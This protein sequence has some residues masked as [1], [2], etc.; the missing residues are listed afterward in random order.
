MKICYTGGGTLGHIYPAIA[1]NETLIERT[2]K[3]DCYWIGRKNSEEKAIVEYN[4]IKYFS[5]NSGKFR[6]YFSFYNFIDIFNVFI[7]YFQSINILKE[8]EVNVIFSKGGFVSV[9]VVYAAHRLHIPV[10]THESD[11][12]MGLATKLNARVSNKV[13]LGFN[14]DITKNNDRY[15]Y[16]GNP[17]RSAL[18]K[19]YN[20]N[21]KEKEEQL[22]KVLIKENTLFNKFYKNFIANFDLSKPII[23][24]TGGSLGALEINNIIWDNLDELLKYY[25]V[26]HQMGKTYKKINKRGY[27][28]V[29]NITDEIGFLYKK[30]TLCISR[31]GAGTLNELINFNVNSLLIPLGHNASRGEQMLNAKYYED[32]GCVNILYER[33][34]SSIFIDTVFNLINNRDGILSRKKKMKNLVNKDTNNHICDVILSQI[35]V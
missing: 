12:T 19:W 4:N 27:I 16:S 17:I 23:L 14:S 10:I 2:D 30:A 24:V 32:R 1:I 11:I 31:S 5:I 25:N 3:V 18:M 35:G 26:Y 22:T 6:R 28:G 34:N 21:T 7:A 33:E 29:I 8:N 13:C 15:I 9:P 20:A